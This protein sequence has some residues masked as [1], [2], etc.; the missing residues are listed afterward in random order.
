M[1]LVGLIHMH[2][3]EGS[4]NNVTDVNHRQTQSALDE[5]CHRHNKRCNETGNNSS[6]EGIG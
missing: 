1:M 6:N 5:G 3:I 2:L 4:G